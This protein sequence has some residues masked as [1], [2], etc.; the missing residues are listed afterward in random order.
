MS[1]GLPTDQRPWGLLAMHPSH[2][3]AALYGPR[4][5]EELNTLLQ[6]DHD[7]VAPDL[8]VLPC[9][10]LERTEVLLS[11]GT[12][13]RSVTTSSTACRTCTWSRTPAGACP[14]GSCSND[15]ASLWSGR[16]PPMPFP[17]PSS[18]WR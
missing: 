4:Q 6:V 10:V 3:A 8:Q 13:P 17:P 15:A 16:L 12:L 2:L 5:R 14:A 18:P 1:T 7:L 11:A 9:G